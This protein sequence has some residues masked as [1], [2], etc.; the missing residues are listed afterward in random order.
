[1]PI[2]FTQAALGTTVDV[3][4]L[5]GTQGLKIPAGTQ[6]NTLF[7]MKGKGIHQVR[8]Y[9]RGSEYVKVVV[10]VPDK[11]TK[12]QKELLVMILKPISLIISN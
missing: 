9:G 3:P 12:K 10:H 4:S 8:G 11:V 1:M 5:N 6:S 7:N 2:S